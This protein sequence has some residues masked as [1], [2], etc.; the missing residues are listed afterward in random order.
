MVRVLFTGRTSL[1][2]YGRNGFVR[3]HGI[4][5]TRLGQNIQLSP[6]TSR[7]SAS[8]AVR[9]IIPADAVDRVCAALKGAAGSG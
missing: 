4:E 1:D 5:A 7:G 2:S 9:L 6:I 8:E 3:T